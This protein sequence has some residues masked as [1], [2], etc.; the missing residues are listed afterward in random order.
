RESTLVRYVAEEATRVLRLPAGRTLDIRQPFSEMGVDSLMAVE[1][2]NRLGTAVGRTLPATL[3]FSYPTVEKLAR[4]LAGEVLH[5]GKKA[6]PA[7]A[8]VAAA[9]NE[10][11]AIVGIGCRLPG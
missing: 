4:Y 10:P 1:L 3:I 8:A 7:V 11:I 9:L 5:L 6:A 2:R